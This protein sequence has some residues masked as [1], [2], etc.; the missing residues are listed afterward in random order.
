MHAKKIPPEKL[1]DGSPLIRAEHAKTV[2]PITPGNIHSLIH[3]LYI[4]ADLIK[5]EKRRY[6]LRAHSLRK[7]FRTACMHIYHY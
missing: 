7:Y 6:E 1:K 2:R 4:T 3:K 5:A